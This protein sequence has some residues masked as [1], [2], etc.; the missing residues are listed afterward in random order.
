MLKNAVDCV[1]VFSTDQIIPINGM[2]KNF[3]FCIF[4]DNQRSNNTNK[5][6]AQEQV[7]HL[8]R[9]LGGSNNTNKWNAQ[10]QYSKL[11]NSKF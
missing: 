9:A 11:Y 6:N 3:L 1:L 4:R 8:H 7:S 5:W 2:L 10:E